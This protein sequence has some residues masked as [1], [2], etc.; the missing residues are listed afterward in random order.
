MK[1]VVKKP[2]RYYHNGSSHN[3]LRNPQHY[4][5]SKK[6]SAARAVADSFRARNE[7]RDR[8]VETENAD[9][10]DDVR[11]GPCNGEYPECR[12]PEYPRNEKCEYPAEVRR[13]HRDRV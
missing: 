11:S 10:A 6:R 9:L 8:V 13:Q 4:S 1:A 2:E 3:R 12:R 7:R 5:D